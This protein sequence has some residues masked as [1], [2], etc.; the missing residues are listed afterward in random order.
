[1]ISLQR[2]KLIEQFAFYFAEKGAILEWHEV[3]KDR[4]RP[5][6]VKR[7]DIQKLFKS[8]STLVKLVKKDY[9]DVLDFTQPS[10]VDDAAEVMSTPDPLAKLRASSVEK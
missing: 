9:A 5:Q 8:Y 2:K 4:N 10:A 6:K 1:M 3:A 7:H